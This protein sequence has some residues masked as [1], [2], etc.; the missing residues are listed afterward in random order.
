M[1]PS[2]SVS[3]ASTGSRSDSDPHRVDRRHG[4]VLG[5]PARQARD[6]VLGVGLALV[7]VA[8]RAVLAQRSRRRLRQLQSLVDHDTIPV[9]EVRDLRSSA[10]RRSRDLVA[11]DLRVAWEGDGPPGV[12]GVVV[13]LRRRRCGSRCRTSPTAA[14]RSRTSRG[15]GSGLGTSRTSRRRASCRTHARMVLWSSVRPIMAGMVAQVR[16]PCT[17]ASRL[18]ADAPAKISPSP[19]S[20]PSRP[21]LGPSGHGG[22]SFTRPHR[23]TKGR[24]SRT[25]AGS[26][27]SRVAKPIL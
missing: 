26:S 13:A 24:T 1:Q 27:P 5:E 12:V 6:A 3:A 15:P 2:G 9:A 25:T 4:D 11:E 18:S 21:P 14:T 22:S 8:G 19:R 23:M 20:R 17:T 16:P 7:R 10:P